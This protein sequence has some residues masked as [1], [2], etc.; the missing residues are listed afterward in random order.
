M[1]QRAK[2][3]MLIAAK[4]T[5][6]AAIKRMGNS[7]QGLQGRVKNLRN[8]IFT[9]NNAFK[10]MAVFLAASTASRFVT[11]AIDQADAFG[12]LSRQ[13]GIAADSLQAYVNAGKLAGVEQSTIEKSLRRLAQSMR[14]ADQGVATYADAYK[15][16]G[17]SVRDSDGNLKE[18]EVV[19][20]QLADRFREM[21]NGATKAAL[22]MEIFGRSGAQLIPMLNEGGDALE[23]WNYQTSA[24]FSQNAEYFNDQIT[25]LGFGF[26]G[27]RKQL[28][29]ALLPTL[30]ELVGVFQ[31]IFDS[32]NDWTGLFKVI[33]VAIR[34]VAFAIMGAIALAKELIEFAKAT[35]DVVGKWLKGDFTGMDDV[36]ADWRAGF[37][38]R[39]KEN[40]ELFDSIIGGTENAPAEYFE[41][42]EDAA[43]TLKM[44]VI[45]IR[46]EMEKSFGENMNA[47]LVAF[48]KT[49]NDMGSM[50]GDTIVKAFKGAEDALVNFVKT[51]K[52]DFK[53]LVDSILSDLARMAIRQSF[54][55]P[56]FNALST[57]IGGLGNQPMSAGGYFDP[58]TGKGIAGPNFGLADGGYVNRPTY[59]MLAEGGE[60]EL[61]IPQSKLASAMA[62]YQ[63]G[64]RGGAIVPGG[65]NAN[66]GG[67]S[68]YAGGG[69]VTVNY[70][71][72]ILNFEGQNYV[73]QSDVGGIINAA[74]NAG[75]ARTMK[76]LKNSRSQRAMVGL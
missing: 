73:K 65:N 19:L 41:E 46:E 17:V 56:L 8:T 24:N 28:A 3:D 34:S 26:D 22:A 68:G 52:L 2:F 60:S 16:L 6:Q 13:T 71:G 66:G 38:E 31:E 35:K 69:N 51:G 70:Q 57:A 25:M 4:T 64:A 75:E 42:G 32:E 40:K 39:F 58:I 48:S 59:A 14:E 33:E 10:A 44:T 1:A 49:L 15:A 72:D 62:R 76:T 21:P 9:L 47:K 74:A 12:K 43:Q 29:D 5:G 27:F 7:M 23:R 37:A 18:S 54:T 63:A 11:G 50:V 45:G 36:K 20:A 55:A 67:G 61:V 30:N 53:S